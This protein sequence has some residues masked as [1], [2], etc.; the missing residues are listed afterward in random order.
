VQVA[1]ELAE[2]GEAAGAAEARRRVLEA[3]GWKVA[4]L[5]PA[6][7]AAAKDDKVWGGRAA[8]GRGGG[9]G[10]GRVAV[11]ALSPADFAAAK[12]DKVWSR[13]AA[14]WCLPRQGTP[15]AALLRAAPLQAQASP[16][17]KAQSAGLTPPAP[18]PAPLST[19]TC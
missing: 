18:S 6:D 4:V 9:R 15:P 2:G 7:F 16:T 12:D 13:P 1:L 11:L 17:Q 3:R 10:A 14:C 5:S 19:P 8:W